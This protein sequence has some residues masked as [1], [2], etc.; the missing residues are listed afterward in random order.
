MKNYFIIITALIGVSF[1]SLAQQ[2]P[3]FT[4]YAFNPI[5]LN[6][7]IAGTHDG[8]SMTGISRIQWSSIEG[9]PKTNM[10]TAHAPI[11]DKNMG[12][13]LTFMND[14]IGISSE[15]EIG[16]VY[17][18][19]IQ[20]EKATLSFGVRGNFD[21]YKATY[22]DIDLGGVQDPNFEGSDLNDFKINFGAGVYYYS[23]K[24][25]VGLSAPYINT[26]TFENG[27]SDFSYQKE[28]LFYLMGGYVFDINADFKIKPYTN[29]KI[30]INA[31][32]Q[33]DVNTSLI[34][35]DMVY[36]GA[37]WRPTDS[38]SVLFEWQI[39]K[40]LRLGYAADFYT[41]DANHLG[42]TAQEFMINYLI[43]LQK[44][45]VVNPRYF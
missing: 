33:I 5:A 34:Y 36:L 7:A 25:Y 23:D 19:N 37:G 17:A 38:F 12:V 22:S 18:Y 35:R 11:G 9:A 3:L 31:P 14:R 20:F 39:Q 45:Q 27:N 28:R 4:Q 30:P 15:N 8:I 16:L 40:N 32:M 29:L 21:F 10:F 13:G 26:N 6:P 41:N 42:G 2:A 1:Q 43:P 44:D 24:Y